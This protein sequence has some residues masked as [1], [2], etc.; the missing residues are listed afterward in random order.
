[1]DTCGGDG[2]RISCCCLLSHH[3]QIAKNQPAVC[4]THTATQSAHTPTH[5]LLLPPTPPLATNTQ[6]TTTTLQLDSST[7][8]AAQHVL[9]TISWC[10]GGQLGSFLLSSLSTALLSPLLAYP[11]SSRDAKIVCTR[12]RRPGAP[13]TGGEGSCD[14][15]ACG[16]VVPLPT[17]LPAAPHAGRNA[18]TTRRLERVVGGRG[19][20][21]R[22]GEREE[23]DAA[24]G[25]E[26][27]PRATYTVS[28]SPPSSSSRSQPSL[29]A[30]LQ[31]GGAGQADA[32]GL[33]LLLALS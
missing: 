1:M 2:P 11:L 30:S 7:T 19:E 26:G 27:W 31:R 18:P 29:T 8:A 16:I 15:R 5:Y 14:P 32:A 10:F 3:L 24:A 33:P 13:Q 21:T 4:T 20:S 6:T 12:A 17:T 23:S 25:K 22:E 28:S 9:L